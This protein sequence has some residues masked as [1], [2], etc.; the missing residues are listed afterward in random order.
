MGPGAAAGGISVPLPQ[1]RER[2]RHRYNQRTPLRAGRRRTGARSS[3]RAPR[4]SRSRSLADLA[5]SNSASAAGRRR[6]LR[7]RLGKGAS[8]EGAPGN[9]SAPRG[10]GGTA[11]ARGPRPRRVATAPLAAAPAPG[12]RPPAEFA[13]LLQPRPESKKRF[14]LGPRV[15]KGPGRW[16]DESLRSRETLRGEQAQPPPFPSQ[17]PYAPRPPRCPGSRASALS[18]CKENPERGGN[19]VGGGGPQTVRLHPGAW[20]PPPPHQERPQS[21]PSGPDSPFSELGSASPRP[22]FSGQGF[23]SRLL[24]TPR[25]QTTLLGRPPSSADKETLPGSPAAP[26]PH[27]ASPNRRDSLPNC[28]PSPP[29]HGVAALSP[30]LPPG[31]AVGATGGG[32]MKFWLGFWAGRTRWSQPARPPVAAVG[33]GERENAG[34]GCAG[35][36]AFNLQ[37]TLG[38]RIRRPLQMLHSPLGSPHPTPLAH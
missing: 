7:R 30:P 6:A 11:G 16:R 8:P 27:P 13:R 33:G 26:R 10:A 12:A 14:P 15:P 28:D 18:S 17:L 4:P 21:P 3:R 24:G 29:H 32:G 37:R 23:L 5:S 31:P 35:R 36:S 2:C 34:C 19:W 20:T 1:P 9:K 22:L 25:T 38:S